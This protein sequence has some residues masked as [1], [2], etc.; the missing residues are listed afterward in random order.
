MTE[1]ARTVLS[2]G[3]GRHLFKEGNAERVRMEIVASE[4]KSLH[5]VIFTSARDGLTPTTTSNGLTLY[6][7]HSRTKFFMPLDAFRISRKIIKKHRRA[8]VVTTQDPFEP[9]VVGLLLK[10]LYRVPLVVQEHGDVLSTMFWRKE[11][12]GNFLR[13]FIGMVVV[14]NADM[15]R[16]V[17]GRTKHALEKLGVRNII[18][19]PVAIDTRPFMTAVPDQSVRTL[20]A[21]DSFIFLTVARFVPQKN[22]MLLLRAFALVYKDNNHARLL[23]VGGGK[24][25]AR[26]N[27]YIATAFPALLGEAPVVIQPWTHNVA[28]M[29]KAVDAYVLTSNYEGWARVLIEAMVAQLPIV[30]TD[31]GCAKEVVIDGVHGMVVPVGDEKALID[32]MTKMVQDTA[33]RDMFVKNLSALPSNRIPGTD[34]SQY[35]VQWAHSLKF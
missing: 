30:T 12:W 20:F 27:D 15:V 19:L 34:I 7:T 10:Y 29:M 31:V 26:L 16:V 17:S 25:E 13:Y 28:G 24:E 6:P 35:G 8:I 11:S 3:Y 9:G 4:V 18:Q 1:L 14:K 5:M 23:I 32:A 33:M 21:E 2:I 22:L